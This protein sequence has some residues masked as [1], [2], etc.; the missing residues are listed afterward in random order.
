MV[1]LVPVAQ[2]MLE[3]MTDE[4]YQN[5]QLHFK[6]LMENSYFMAR[7]NEIVP[8]IQQACFA[9]VNAAPTFKRGTL[10][11]RFFETGDNYYLGME[12]SR[13]YVAWRDNLATELVSPLNVTKAT[14]LLKDEQLE[15]LR[16]TVMHHIDR[17]WY[18]GVL[19]VIRTGDVYNP[20]ARHRVP[21]LYLINSYTDAKLGSLQVGESFRISASPEEKYEVL[22]KR[23]I[24]VIVRNVEGYISKLRRSTLVRREGDL[25]RGPDGNIE[26]RVA[27]ATF[28]VAH[29]VNHR[30][31]RMNNVEKGYVFAFIGDEQA[32]PHFMRYSGLTGACINAMLFANFIKRANDGIPFVE[33][34][35]EYTAE[36]N[37]S[38]GEVVKRG[39]GHNYGEDG[40]LR[41]GF[42]YE[43][44]VNY[45]FS[46]VTEYTESGQDLDYIL[47]NDWM[48]RLAASLVPRG[49]ELNDAFINGLYVQLHRH[50]FNK[51]VKEAACIESDGTL[52][53]QL[54]IRGA[55]CKMDA[56][57]FW[58][59]FLLASLQIDDDK[60][61][62]LRDQHIAIA[63]KIEKTLI[64]VIDHAREAY[65]YNT[66]LSSELVNQPKPVDSIVD[67]LAV[68]AQNFSTTLT[69][70]AAFAAGVL[71][72]KPVGDM[73]SVAFSEI[74]ALLNIWISFGTMTNSSRYR[75]RNEEAR[76]IFADEKL[77]GVMK[78]VFVL[79]SRNEQD[80]VTITENPF[81]IDLE[82][83][84]AAFLDTLQYYDYD[85]PHEFTAA[86]LR[87]KRNVNDPV[88]IY[89][90]MDLIST[91]ILVDTCH[92][93]SYVQET[94]V[95][96]YGSLEEMLRLFTAY[97]PNRRDENAVA[98][99]LFYRLVNFQEDLESTLQR[100]STRWGF[101][102]RRRLS[103]WDAVAM[104]KYLYNVLCCSSRFCTIKTA[105]I[106][107][108]TLSIIQHTRHLSSM[109]D[110][111]VLC[112]E[113]RDLDGLYW[114]TR[115]SDIAS[116]VFMNGC[117]VFIASFLIVIAFV[118]RNEVLSDL[119]TFLALASVLGAILA[120]FH[121]WR[122]FVILVKLML[123]LTDKVRSANTDE[124]FSIFKIRQV[125]FAQSMLTLTLLLSAAAS[126][127]AL[128]WSV[129][130]K[131]YSESISVI[132][133]VPFFLAFGSVCGVALATI[134]FFVV[135]FV[136]RYKLP[137]TLGEFVCESFRSEIEDMY[138]ILSVPPNNIDTKQVQERETWEYVAREFL[139]SYRFD[140]VFA[141]DRFGSILQYIQGGMDRRQ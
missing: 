11:T 115:E 85:E 84:V 33:R 135:E 114:A 35:Q 61:K 37:W 122:K 98:W 56:E 137:P 34:Y 89:A 58:R 73:I 38:N 47:S 62:V 43:C 60:K 128:P 74:F 10:Q 41:P 9:L 21:R 40:F 72:L 31:L 63:I 14:G 110:S 53:E 19:E 138:A 69:Q 32:T 66:R 104:F 105:P 101:V 25:T 141:A 113:I 15:E 81:A 44:V 130:N 55:N 92:V 17:L 77:L 91:K 54:E 51:F 20:G 16:C 4:K 39:T 18:D 64:Q 76:V 27:L 87:L 48:D 140:A 67:K 13:E 78:A 23:P 118:V 2:K 57:A 26:S 86:F 46:K 116:L 65:L 82:Q 106:S 71:A 68:E 123:T 29:H 131:E 96:I 127:V 126:A 1:R 45:L 117:V 133:Q 28:P 102:K 83:K 59:E 42:S 125:A 95:N 99:S 111:K 129:A 112:R 7:H 94:L 100:G 36:T 22:I 49:M 103:Q 134:M 97:V 70:S 50:V 8:K 139:H 79:M 6:S 120:M 132:D 90:F 80:F 107:T 30:S 5:W 136:V 121:L 109:H 108:R 24:Y 75:I 119:A 93:N 52:R 88:E 3:Y 124:R 12:L